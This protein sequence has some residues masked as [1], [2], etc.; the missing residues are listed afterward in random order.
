MS[1]VTLVSPLQMLNFHVLPLVL[2][3]FRDKAAV[4]VVRLVFNSLRPISTCQYSRFFAVP[5]GRETFRRRRTM[6]L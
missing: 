2:E 3:I 4:T 5:L 6:S 1:S